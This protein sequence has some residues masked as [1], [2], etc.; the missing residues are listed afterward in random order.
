[1]GFITPFHPNKKATKALPIQGT[2]T[3]VA[4][5]ESVFPLKAELAIFVAPL[6]KGPWYLS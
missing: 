3:F 6:L 5:L 2:W 4:F 1:M